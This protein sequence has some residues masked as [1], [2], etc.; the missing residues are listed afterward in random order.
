MESVELG[1]GGRGRSRDII[2]IIGTGSEVR[3]KKTD[4]GIVLVRGDWEDND[5][6][7]VIINTTGAYDRYR[8]YGLHN[9]S[10]VETIAS[11][12]YAF[13]AAGRTNSGSEV[14]AIITPGAVFKLNSKYSSTWYMWTEEGWV[15]ETPEERNARLALIEVEQGG[16]E[17]L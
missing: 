11:G 10:G 6:C 3:A 16:G 7:L 14:L 9:A 8:S 2:P 1:E 17:W 12:V 5:R 4:E 13:G 15:V